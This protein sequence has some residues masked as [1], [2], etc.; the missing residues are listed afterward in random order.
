MGPFTE[1]SDG[2]TAGVLILLVPT[3]SLR[4]LVSRPNCVDLSDSST[5]RKF[6][7]Q[8]VELGRG[9]WRAS[10]Q[11]IGRLTEHLAVVGDN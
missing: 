6:G 11:S 7:A 4:F 2:E 10:R 1:E 3:V 8:R 5:F 9:L